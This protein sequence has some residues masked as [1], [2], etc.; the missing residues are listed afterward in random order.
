MSSDPRTG[1][2]GKKFEDWMVFETDDEGKELHSLEFSVRERGSGRPGIIRTVYVNFP[3]SDKFDEFVE[4]FGGWSAALAEYYSDLFVYPDEI[5]EILR[6]GPGMQVWAIQ[7]Y[8][9]LRIKF[10]R[11]GMRD[12]FYDCLD[13]EVDGMNLEE[14][15][16]WLGRHAGIDKVY[17]MFLSVA[18]VDEWLK[19]NATY[20]LE[21]RYQIPRQSGSFN[22]SRKKAD[23]PSPKYSKSLFSLQDSSWL[24]APNTTTN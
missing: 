7:T 20:A 13:P 3:A 5:T 19:K 2:R 8:Y 22:M 18:L 1:I 9:V 17:H 21:T 4:K 12:L 23:S 24:G 14:S 15:R 10:F 16:A 6:S 11:D